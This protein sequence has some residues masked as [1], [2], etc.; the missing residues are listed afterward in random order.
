MV[1][2]SWRVYSRFEASVDRDPASFE[3][4][5][6]WLVFGGRIGLRG[7]TAR[8]WFVLIWSAPRSRVDGFLGWGAGQSRR[9]VAP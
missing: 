1:K 6:M 8:G 7:L 3:G 4:E 5:A 2:T 9:R